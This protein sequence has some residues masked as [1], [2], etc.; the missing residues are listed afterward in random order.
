MHIPDGYL[1]PPTYLATYAA[2][3]PL[4]GLAARKARTALAARRAPLLAICGGV[5]RS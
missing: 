4:W 5:L 3:I 1:G 2:C